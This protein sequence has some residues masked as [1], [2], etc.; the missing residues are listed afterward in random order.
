[1]TSCCRRG[2]GSQ[3]LTM[4]ND[5]RHVER[6]RSAQRIETRT[7]R[8]RGFVGLQLQGGRSW[9]E[10]GRGSPFARQT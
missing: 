1:M 7:A 10:R 8:A 3:G 2:G 4:G 9:R 6:G 5:G